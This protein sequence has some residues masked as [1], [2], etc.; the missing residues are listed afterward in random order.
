MPFESWFSRKVY[1]ARVT[2][3]EGEGSSDM[4]LS[5]AGGAMSKR[6]LPL[7]PDGLSI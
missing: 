6:L 2:W 1:G 5:L 7:V 4:D 3:Q